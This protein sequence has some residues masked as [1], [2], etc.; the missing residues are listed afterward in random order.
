M[1][2]YLFGLSALVLAIVFSAFTTPTTAVKF[3]LKNSF[4]GNA[5]SYDLQSGIIQNP[6]NWIFDNTV[7][8][9]GGEYG[10][11]FSIDDANDQEYYHD[12]GFG[13]PE[14]NTS[15]NVE[16]PLVPGV[17][18][19]DGDNVRDVLMVITTTDGNDAVPGSS[20]TR[21]YQILQSS[22]TV[23]SPLQKVAP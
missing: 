8:C 13:T 4:L 20:P 23:Q 1:K 16:G 18:D 6:A 9:A 22:T 21:K 17:D 14:L 3:R 12:N 7:S 11:S 19:L 10:C 2:K 15:A 5:S